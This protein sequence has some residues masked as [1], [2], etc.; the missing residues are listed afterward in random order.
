[1]FAHDEGSVIKT[2]MIDLIAVFLR[3]VLMHVFFQRGHT[4]MHVSATVM[5]LRGSSERR[6]E[7]QHG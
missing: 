4:N 3:F 6:S 7:L 2:A 1:M 5:I